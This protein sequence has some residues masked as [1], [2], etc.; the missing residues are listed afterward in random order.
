MPQATPGII[1]LASLP[2]PIPPGLAETAESEGLTWILAPDGL[3]T[4]DTTQMQALLTAVQS[5]PTT[6][7]LAY[8]QA[9]TQTALDSFYQ[10]NFNFDFLVRGGQSTTITGAQIGSAIATIVNNYRSIRASIAQAS[11]IAA[12][13]A[14]NVTSGW[15]SNP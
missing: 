15:P 3:H 11:T 9:L 2:S 4:N 14:I 1:S 8:W 6:A 7:T 12:V 10:T 5:S 13:Q